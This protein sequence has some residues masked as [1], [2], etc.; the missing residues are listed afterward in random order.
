MMELEVKGHSGCKIEVVREDNE[1]FVY[2]STKDLHY[3]DRLQLQAK[4]QQEA[5]Q[6]ELQHIRIPKIFNVYKDN[7]SV[8]IKM[9]YVYSKNFIGYFEYA[10]FEQISYFIKA[11]CLF[12][13]YEINN[14][15]LLMVNGDIVKR[16]FDDVYQKTINNEALKNDEEIINV[17]NQSAIHFANVKDMLLPVGKCHGDLTFSNILFNGNNYYLIDFLDS[18]IESPLL[19]IVKIRQDSAYLW[20]RLMFEGNY[21]EI[22]LKIVAD[23]IDKEIVHYAS[24]YEWFHYYPL[25]QLMNFL[26]VLQYAHEE[27]VI[28]YLKRIIKQLLH[29]F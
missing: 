8:T 1:L 2:K 4:K 16:K 19:D 27:K 6:L 25:F 22:R 10:G 5:E 29:E 26:R 21:D 11:L 24:Q 28:V 18:F 17:M 12:L 7:Y 14:S 9:E 23:K 15:P 13:N 20:S 3:L